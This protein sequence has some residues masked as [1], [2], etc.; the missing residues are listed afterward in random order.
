MQNSKKKNFL[1]VFGTRPEALKLIPLYLSL[2]K[3][4]NVDIISTFQHDSLIEGII[5]FYNIP[6]KKIVFKKSNDMIMLTINILNLF[7]KLIPKKN[8]IF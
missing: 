7:Q 5:G 6:I 3:T 8:M 2:K 4:Y 1:I